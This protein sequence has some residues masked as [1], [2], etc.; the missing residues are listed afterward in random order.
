MDAK[1]SPVVY[2]FFRFLGD[3]PWESKNVHPLKEEYLLWKSRSLWANEEQ[4]K[5]KRRLLFVIEHVLFFI[6]PRSLFLCVFKTV[7]EEKLKNDI[8]SQ[9]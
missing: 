5:N 2:H 7:Q 9:T 4:I 3:Y 8:H 1:K 6:L